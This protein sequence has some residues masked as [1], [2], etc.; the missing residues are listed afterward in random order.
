MGSF[1]FHRRR[2]LS[3]R[4]ST[5]IASYIRALFSARAIVRRKCHGAVNKWCVWVP[6][7]PYESL[8]A[9]KC[10]TI[11]ADAHTH[12][13]KQTHMH[14]SKTPRVFVLNGLTDL[15]KLPFSRYATVV[16]REKTPTINKHIFSFSWPDIRLLCSVCARWTYNNDSATVLA[17]CYCIHTHT[18]IY[19]YDFQ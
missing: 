16:E 4:K 8:H 7:I 19:I 17:V 12:T 6:K 18:Y 10:L 2:E 13:H 15:W 11:S 9:R 3:G 5:N 1:C 14:A